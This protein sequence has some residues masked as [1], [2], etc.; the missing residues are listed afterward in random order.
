MASYKKYKGIWL[1]SS[2][3]ASLTVRTI[4]EDGRIKLAALDFGEDGNYSARLV[5]QDAEIGAHYALDVVGLVWLDIFDDELLT[6]RARA[7]EFRIYRAGVMGCIIQVAG[8]KDCEAWDL[9][10]CELCATKPELL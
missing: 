6:F 1:G 8:L 9:E 2:D 4:G 3:V 10:S 5:P 7:D